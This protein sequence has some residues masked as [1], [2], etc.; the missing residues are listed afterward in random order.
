[1]SAHYRAPVLAA[2]VLL[3]TGAG[4]V[5]Y[6]GG[7]H[8]TPSP[9]PCRHRCHTGEPSHTPRPH[10]TKTP[11]PH[12]T[13][14]ATAPEPTPTAP[15]PTPTA[16]TPT[17]TPTRPAPPAATPKPAPVAGGHKHPLP[18]PHHRVTIDRNADGV[19]DVAGPDVIEEG[20]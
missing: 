6:A 2:L 14:T 15:E 3:L 8:G 16:S 13:P 10:P 19:Q 20:Y 18:K 17:P 7:D 5:A 12:P 4:G 9:G 11:R 1:M